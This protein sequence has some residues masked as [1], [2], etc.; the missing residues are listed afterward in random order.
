MA[1]GRDVWQEEGEPFTRIT[2]KAANEMIADGNVQLIDVRNQDEWDAGHVPGATLIPVDDLFSR[3]DELDHDKKLLFICAM[4]VRS[5]LACEMAAAFEYTN[6]F[7][8]EGGTGAWAEDGY[9]IE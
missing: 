7:N 6:L 3:I 9:P 1:S 4:G 5:A 8:I 2:P